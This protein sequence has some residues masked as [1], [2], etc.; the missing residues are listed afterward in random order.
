MGMVLWGLGLLLLLGIA[1][2]WLLRGGT[3]RGAQPPQRPAA[4]PGSQRGRLAAIAAAPAEP[5]AAATDQPAPAALPLHAAELLDPLLTAPLMDALRQLPRPPRALHQLMSPTFL[6][7]ATSAELAHLVMSE[8]AV[9]A[10]II[11]TANSPLYGLQQPVTSIGQATTFLGLASV[12]LMCQQHLLAACFAPRDEAQRREFDVLWR[13]SGIA[14]ELCLQLAPRLHVPEP[15]TLA[16]LLVLSFLGRQ[17]AAA[18]L[19]DAGVLGTMNAHERALHEQ[20][21]LGLAAHELGHLLMRAWELPLELVDEARTLSALCFDPQ[22][23][24]APEREAALALGAFCALL[25][26]RLARGQLA[27]GLD[28]LAQDDSPDMAAL[29]R[30]LAR[31]PLDALAA[32]L[33]APATLRVLGRMMGRPLD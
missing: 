13:A 22:R 1:G 24:V 14:G 18:L 3:A 6:Q 15:G 12:R 26:E 2:A 27:T 31:P 19:P 9:A 30:R 4:T 23:A 28:Q 7:T 21:E 25:G 16:T 20:C 5:P 10:R 33:Q 29:R 8:P 11:A 17:S 32:E